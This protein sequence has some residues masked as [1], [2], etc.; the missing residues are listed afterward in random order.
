MITEDRHHRVD[1]RESE[2][3]RDVGGQVRD[4]VGIRRDDHDHGED[5]DSGADGS[6]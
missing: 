4:V 2:N 5:R 1:V 3:Q 6:R